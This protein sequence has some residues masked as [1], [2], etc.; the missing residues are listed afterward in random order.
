MQETWNKTN[1]PSKDMKEAIEAL[2]GAT[3]L[4]SN[5]NSCKE[6]VRELLTIS[7][8]KDFLNPNPIGILNI[9]FQKKG[10]TPPKYTSTRIGGP[11]HQAKFICKLEGEYEGK[12]HTINSSVHSSKKKAEKNVAKRFL[13]VI[14]EEERLEYFHLRKIDT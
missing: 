13:E 10:N 3:Y 14:G 5:F 9:L 1:I 11:D 8:N 6:V 2:L 7:I 4:T 12:Q